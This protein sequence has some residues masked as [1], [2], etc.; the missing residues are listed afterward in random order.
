MA[1]PLQV[2][3]SILPQKY[4]IER[5]GGDAVK[6]HVMVRP[7][8]SPASYDMT[9]QQMVAIAGAQVYFRIGVAFEDTWLPRL[10]AANPQMR[11]VD[12]RNGIAL[13]PMAVTGPESLPAHGN[14]G[15]PAPPYTG[16]LDP[17]IWTSPPLVKQQAA[18]V[19][20][21]LCALAPDQRARFEQGY[22]RFAADLDALDTDMRKTLAGKTERSFMVFH[23]A[24]GYFASAYSLQQMTVE[25]QGKEPG[26]QTLARIIDAA[27]REQV[28]VVFVQSQFSSTT[29]LAVARAIGGE[30]VTIDPL[31]EDFLSNTRS[32]SQ[33]LA[34]AMR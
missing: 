12:T 31:A 10:Q 23:P 22:A 16:A 32:V 14:I 19:R 6:V 4:F 25:V 3:V 24:W 9:S 21:A 7:G 15:H 5:V 1:E 13:Q 29:A 18:T 33:A 34:K 8:Q 30:V 20:D 2:F 17:H 28:R 11:V 27:R 26:A